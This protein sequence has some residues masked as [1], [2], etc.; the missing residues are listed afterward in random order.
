MPDSVAAFRDLRHRRETRPAALAGRVCLR[1]VC[2][3]VGRDG[4]CFPCGD[5]ASAGGAD[6]IHD[7]GP[8]LLLEGVHHADQRDRGDLAEAAE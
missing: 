7:V 5:R 4:G 8:E 1:L 2:E 3:L 6:A